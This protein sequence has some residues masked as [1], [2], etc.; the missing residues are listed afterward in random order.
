MPSIVALTSK[1]F[2]DFTT[3]EPPS[4]A[5]A[6]PETY[7]ASAASSAWFFAALE[8]PVFDHIAENQELD[9]SLLRAI[10]ADEPQLLF[11]MMAADPL[12]EKTYVQ[13]MAKVK[14]VGI[15]AEDYLIRGDVL[16][17][18]ASKKQLLQLAKD[19]FFLSIVVRVSQDKGP[20]RPRQLAP[21]PRDN[22]PLCY[23]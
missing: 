13:S 11:A 22:M 2:A 4:S 7:F 9:P 16:G 10:D 15:K 8:L 17:A 12:F 3:A 6:W 23:T 19:P 18:M 21:A 14:A 1:E 5:E 20:D